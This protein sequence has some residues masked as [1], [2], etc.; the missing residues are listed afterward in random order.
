MLTYLGGMF[1]GWGLGANDSANVFGTAVSSKMVKYRTA[2]IIIAIFV[3]LG[4][5]F[6]GAEG[7]ETLKSLSP[8]TPTS[9]AVTALAAAFTV[10]IMTGLKIPVSTSQA[11]VGAMVMLSILRRQSQFEELPK[12]IICWVG[13]PIGGMLF[14]VIFYSAFRF[15]L[16]KYKPTVFWLDPVT[17]GGACVMRMLWRLC[18]GR[19][20]CRQRFGG[21]C[22]QGHADSSEW[23]V[24]GW[25]C[26]C[27]GRNYVQQKSYYDCWEGYR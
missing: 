14:S 26:H 25:D 18:S 20:Q 22:W 4:A 8:Q 13:T 19:K 2:V 16:N 11:V 3:I 21:I 15:F 23:C 12:I 1:L 24:F 17:R 6:Q 7:I 10:V 27:S 9:A 5:W